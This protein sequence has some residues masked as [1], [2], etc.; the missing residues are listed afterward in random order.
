MGV[1]FKGI[2]GELLVSGS[3][4]T[5]K[6]I[7]AIGNCINMLMAIKKKDKEIRVGNSVRN[8]RRT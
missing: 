2:F 7:R 3:R 5:P 4:V 6:Q 1:R 8:G